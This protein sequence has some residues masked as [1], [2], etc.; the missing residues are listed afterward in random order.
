[1]LSSLDF[2]LYLKKRLVFYSGPALYLKPRWL[3]TLKQL[4]PNLHNPIDTLVACL[5]H[6]SYYDFIRLRK[7]RYKEEQI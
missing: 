7:M 6:I 1:M 3:G 2:D 5:R 4:Q